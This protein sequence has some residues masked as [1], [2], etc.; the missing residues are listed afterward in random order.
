VLHDALGLVVARAVMGKED[1][2]LGDLLDGIDADP[3]PATVQDLVAQP[4]DHAAALLG[5]ATQRFVYDV[6][7][8]ARDGEPVV[9]VTLSRELHL[10][11]ETGV[12]SPV[13]TRLS[14]TDGFGREIQVKVRAE[15]DARTALRWVGT[16]RL[17]LNN[18]GKPVRRYDP[19]FSSTHLFEPEAEITGVSAELF[20]DPVERVVA[21]IRPDHSY[22]EVVYSPWQQTTYDVNDTVTGDPRTDPRIADLVAGFFAAQDPG[23]TTWY[24][25]RID[26]QL[27][28]GEHDAAVKAAAHADTPS[29]AH[30]DPIGRPFLTIGENRFTVDGTLVEQRHR[31]KVV[32]DI[33]GNQRAVLDG[34]DRL[35]TTYDYDLDGHRLHQSSVDAGRLWLLDDAAGHPI[36]SWDS[37]RLDRRLAY[38]ELR[39]PTG[40]HVT[41]NGQERQTERIVYGD[42]PADNLRLQV[43]KVHDSAGI[44]TQ[45]GYDLAGNAVDTRRDLLPDYVA[46][47]DWATDP[48]A[49]D[50]SFRVQ[51]AY[52]A[53]NRPLVLV[54]PDASVYRPSFNEAGLL[55]TVSVRL[56]GASE[57]TPFITGIEYDERGERLR[58][59]YGNGAATAYGYDPDTHRLASVRTTR[60]GGPDPTATQLFADPGVVQ[61]LR[62]TYDP[63]GNVTRI[64]DAALPVIVHAGLV[65]EPLR[66]F[67][68]D[69]AYRVIEATGRE[70][71]GQTQVIPGSARD[72]PFA[73][74]HPNDLQAMRTYTERYDY[75]DTG[76][77]TR[78][79]HHSGSAGWNR[80]Y[81]YATTGHRVLRTTIADGTTIAENYGYTD[82]QGNDAG[83]CIT[84]INAFGLSWDHKQRLVRAGLGGGGTAYL[85]Y[86]AADQRVRK[87]VESSP[88]VRLNERI[89]FEGFEIHRQYAGGQVRTERESLNVLA[90][91]DR[92]ALVE[93]L[94]VDGGTAVADPVSLL[95]Y[96]F[97]DHLDSSSAELDGS[98][99]LIAL[100]EY[101]PYGTTSFQAGR[102][103]TEVN[104]RRY[105]YT[106][107]ERD[108]ET[109]LCYFGARYYVPWLGRWCSPDPLG[110]VD[111]PNAYVYARNN[112]L[113][114][115][116]KPGTDPKPAVRTDNY[117]DLLR[118][119][120]A[121]VEHV[122]VTDEALERRFAQYAS[123]KDT[124]PRLRVGGPDTV[125]TAFQARVAAFGRVTTKLGSFAP[126]GWRP[127]PEDQCGT[128]AREGASLTMAPGESVTG[129]GGVL[130]YEAEKQRFSTDK[131]ASQVALAQIRRHVD[132]GRALM[133]GI[134]EPGH[135]HVVDPKVQPVTD[136]FV[137]IY[138]Y[139][140]DST[141]RIVALFAKDNAISAV[142]EV[143]FTVAPDGSISKPAEPKR[144]EGESYLRQEYQLSEV[145]FHTGFEYTG[146]ERPTNDAGTVMF[147]PVPKPP[148][149][150]KK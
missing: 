117:R 95:R 66:T 63:A 58:V 110:L 126:P 75:D 67:G 102:S 148:D 105:R 45:A 22:D 150:K 87:V 77:L 35:V 109:G 26:N 5:P 76:N 25:Q 147:W 141:G 13:Q 80:Q 4:P 36:R 131:T 28:P 137:D 114:Y 91:G 120:I 51:R 99:A 24:Q 20:Y 104:L 30:L 74:G 7:R 27:G 92:I 71:I 133:A 136:H 40:V 15:P 94:T 81:E 93:T 39:R 108:E 129:G 101:H 132:G 8:F 29:H 121:N 86:D 12:P 149:P 146:A 138:G 23:W 57:A 50:G 37:R 113:V 54:S 116:D 32:F 42:S 69:A 123:S 52:D 65:V 143:R 142:G 59:E 115:T 106:G 124:G 111:G 68:Y 43:H 10:H 140:T 82:A 34:P 125:E 6:N 61:D 88:G 134:S 19:F 130:L 83:G 64:E 62:Y 84:A 2:D 14:F 145:R 48:P 44:L 144:P 18:K 127:G 73:G 33:R 78:V 46:D 112:P 17:V 122:S 72:Y 55:E 60:P 100:E 49:G 38:D 128:L 70:H 79:R 135:G 21:T 41:E 85:R 96:E 139:E 9:A 31:T 3:P 118:D 98:G 56:R 119:A 89:W 47:V 97:N 53:L 103:A 1:D 90:N 11:Q 16:G 107:K